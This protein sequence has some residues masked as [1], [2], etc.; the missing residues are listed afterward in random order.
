[1]SFR[2]ET[3]FTRKNFVLAAGCLWAA[4]GQAQTGFTV[5]G[6]GYRTPSGTVTAAPGQVLTVSVYGIA[7]R[8]P[9]PVFPIANNG[10][11]TEVRGISA[12]FVQGPVTIQ[13]QIRG[14]QQT[15]CPA[16][17]SCAPAT[18]LTIQIP[19][20]LNPESATKAGLRIRE[21]GELAAE[22]AIN[23]VIDSVHVINTC[24]QTGIYLSVAFGIPPEF[25]VPMITHTS[26]HLV[27]ASNPATGGETLIMWAYGLGAVDHPVPTECCS[28]PIQLPVAVHPFTVGFSYADPGRFP[29]RRLDPVIPS[30]T[31]MPGAG[32][33]QLHF[34]A[35]TV[36]GSLSPCS[37]KSGNLRILLSGPSSADGAEVCLQQTQAA[38]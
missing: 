6:F 12:D 11:P 18:T 36:P 23:A 13:L 15:A 22:V 27:S 5:A 26:G 28:V 7:T 16:S 38:P 34:T 3:S 1:M 35:P 4:L 30:Y 20:E 21:G 24:D 9:S 31:G 19:Y 2:L 10:F 37:P 29:L 25:C 17:G 32:L 33:Y 14:V 8:I